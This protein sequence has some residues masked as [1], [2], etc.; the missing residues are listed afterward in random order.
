MRVAVGMSGGVDSSVAALLL[1]EA[2]HEVF[3][4]SMAIWDQR[5]APGAT[6]A[7]HACYGPDEAQELESARKICATLNIPFYVFDC[8]EQY[9][10]IVLNY[11]QAEY[12]AGR[13]P[14]PCIQCNHLIK[15]GVLPLLIRQAEMP[16]DVF[17]TGHYAQV[18]RH[19]VTGRYILRKAKDVRKDQSYFL[20]RL[21][22]AQL[23]QV[24]FPLAHYTKAEVRALARK[25]QLGVAE[26][27]E[28][29]DFYSGD[30]QDLLR[31]PVQVGQIV[32]VNGAILGQHQGLWHYTIGQRK[33]LGIAASEPLYVVGL[34]ANTNTVMVGPRASIYSAACVVKHL[35]WIAIANLTESMSVHVKLRSFH[36]AAE[37]RIAPW[38]ANSVQVTFQT[39]Q[40]AIT[41][42]QSAVFYDE[43]LVVGG[44]IIETRV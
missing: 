1:K 11:F 25:H 20:Y 39:P 32:H 35:N 12:Q 42:G 2:G 4:V 29:Q 37:A 34:D 14:N 13:T 17:A 24:R 18:D 27:K 7:K 31:L 21:S 40:E 43:D 5:C 22:Q 16:F 3:G 44:G 30:Y 10:E 33:G 26:S 9:R 38:T 8:V 15:F 36:K 6:S 41:P 19:P 28:S 23:A